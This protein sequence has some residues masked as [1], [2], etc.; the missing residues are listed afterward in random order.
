MKKSTFGFLYICADNKSEKKKKTEMSALEI[1]S[2]AIGVLYT[3][4]REGR[5]KGLFEGN[6]IG[7]TTYYI[8]ISTGIYDFI[9]KKNKHIASVLSGFY[10]SLYQGTKD[11]GDRRRRINRRIVLSDDFSWACGTQSVHFCGKSEVQP[12]RFTRRT[13]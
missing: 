5:E 9:K 11:N 1:V 2:A 13:L 7:S 3:N 12:N 6:Y 10:H 8:H 4:R